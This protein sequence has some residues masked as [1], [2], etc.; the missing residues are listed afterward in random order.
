[1]RHART[2][3]AVFAA[4]LPAAPA[5][6]TLGAQAP[7]AAAREP[8]PGFDAY[9]DAAL[10]TWQVPGLALALVR[11]DSVV[12]ARG[13]G[14]REL[15]KPAPVDARTVFAIGSS[16][17]AF[18]AAA[19]AML[20]DEQKVR[21]DAPAATYLPGFQLFDP[22]AS[23]ELTVR[24]L[25]S[26]RSG[27]ARGELVWYGS[28]YDRDEILRHVR[29]LPP[30]WSFRSQFGYQNIM[31]VA[32]GQVVAHTANASWDDFVAR[33]IFTPLGMTSS[34]TSLRA[35]AG[36]TDLATPH[37]LADDSAVVTS[38]G[39]ARVGP[40]NVGPANAG[41]ASVGP[42]VVR[43][44]VWRNI[45]NAG[46]AGS[47]NS[48]VLDMAQWVRLQL[49]DGLY[50]GRRLVS[51]RM[52]AEMHTPQIVVPLDTASK[53]VNPAT[54]FSTYGMGWFLEDYRGREVW[55]HGGN[56]DGFTALVAMLPEEKLGLVILT[57]MNG[58]GLPTA[59]MRRVFDLH[60][61]GPARDWSGDLRR[62]AEE[63]RI[64][65]RAGSAKLEAQRVPNTRPSLPLSAYA[66][67]Y[68]DSLYGTVTVREDGGTL[69]MAFG[70][71]W[72]GELRHWH[73]DIF[74]SRFD[75][76]VLGPFFVEFHPNAQAKV[77]EVQLELVGVPTTFRRRPPRPDSAAAAASGRGR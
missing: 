56:V 12:Y 41:A 74:R 39:P 53:R 25:L 44:V 18:T 8:Y 28:G 69:Q 64:R 5:A 15:G 14:V 54:H 72:H 37:A 60:L 75:T 33:R 73:F 6:A 43:P 70:P 3:A 63:Q 77:D 67:T 24:D 36:R 45:D 16:S 68:V 50:G 61:G 4:A 47:I 38:A 22:Y 21:L 32:A 11:N 20:A 34:S 57:N 49:G 10:K 31:Y 23:R 76:P 59:L 46:P 48:T 19:V 65:A 27:L 26:H 13:Y 2:L 42:G 66:G 35:L 51:R 62:R 55:H 1:M 9:V 7:A 52:M 17:K 58:T 29:F 40:T 71:T 30:S